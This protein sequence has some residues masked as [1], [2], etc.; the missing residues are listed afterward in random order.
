M[1]LEPHISCLLMLS[2]TT[3]ILSRTKGVRCNFTHKSVVAD[4]TRR[5]PALIQNFSICF[6]NPICCSF[7]LSL[8][9]LRYVTSYSVLKLS[10]VWVEPNPSSSL[11]PHQIALILWEVKPKGTDIYIASHCVRNSLRSAQVWI[12]QFLH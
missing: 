10:G 4:V 2:T 9:S 3:T 8:N 11:N 6:R 5:Q 12:T 1:E 7:Q